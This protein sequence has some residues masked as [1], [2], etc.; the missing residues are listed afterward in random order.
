MWSLARDHTCEEVAPGQV[1]RGGA[2]GGEVI[3]SVLMLQGEDDS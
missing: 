3:V 1:G 2:S